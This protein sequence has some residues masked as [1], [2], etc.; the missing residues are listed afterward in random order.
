MNNIILIFIILI[1][2]NDYCNRDFSSNQSNKEI[3]KT[4]KNINPLIMTEKEEL[5]VLDTPISHLVYTH[6]S[7]DLNSTVSEV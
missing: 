1:N 2:M 7:N 3:T 5:L 6:N 4:I